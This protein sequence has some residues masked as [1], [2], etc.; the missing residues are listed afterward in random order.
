MGVSPLGVQLA[1]TTSLNPHFNIRSTGNFFNYS[2]SF[3][4]EGIGANAKLNMKSAGTALDIYP[5]HTGF[6]ISPGILFYNNNQLT[7]TANVA[8]GTSFTLNDQTYYS[9]KAN[10]VTGATPITGDALLSLH[11]TSPAF[12]I[13]T[14]WGN[15][16]PRNSHSSFPFEVG[17]ALTGAPSLNVNLGGWACY[18][19]AQTLC[20]N[21]NSKTDPIAQEI[22]SN[23]HVQ[24][25]KWTN[26]IE[27]LKTY[28]IA[29]FGVAYSFASRRR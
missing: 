12:T 9:A 1:V 28:P 4:T 26:D 18:D 8:P 5:F 20:T 29:S 17:V 16:L 6:R 21:I 15:T 22:Q 27:P 24:V 7:A 3:T 11:K 25:A 13:T 23:L 10:S 2:T 19:Q 14:G